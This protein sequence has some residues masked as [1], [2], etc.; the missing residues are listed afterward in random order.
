[1][2][3]VLGSILLFILMI[4][5]PFLLGYKELK[6]K[7]DDS[8]L[9]VNRN[10]VREPRYFGQSFRAL[11][12]K[13]K[14]DWEN[15]GKGIEIKI[16]LSKDELL[17]IGQDT[18]T[19]PIAAESLFMYKDNSF[20][21]AYSTFQKEV[22]CRGNMDSGRECLA[23]AIAVDGNCYFGDNSKVV[24]WLD[25]EGE[26]V[27]GNDVALGISAASGTGLRLGHGCRFKRLYGPYITVGE[28]FAREL[29]VKA[30]QLISALPKPAYNE[31][32]Y[33]IDKVAPK[34]DKEKRPYGPMIF[35][36]IIITNRTL[37]IHKDMVVLGSIKAKK[38]LIIED[39]VVILGDV[40]CEGN[41]TVGNGC[42]LGNVVFCQ[43]NI[44][45]GAG[46]EVGQAGK[47][48]SLIARGKILLDKGVTIYGYVLT[49]EGGETL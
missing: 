22:Y 40:F 3:Y 25:V 34:E 38:D 42:V 18:T 29:G 7:K 8:N 45:L 23:R 6:E 19:D 35:P 27:I 36:K 9:Y 32:E 1:M 47:L 15:A 10:Y 41:L 39:N 12:N 11:M 21:P 17:N 43:E 24:R 46:T 20:I 31:I 13:A 26:A 28:P 2:I 44:T 48:K 37:T 33:N 4:A 5:L 16:H 30:Q 14:G 49:D